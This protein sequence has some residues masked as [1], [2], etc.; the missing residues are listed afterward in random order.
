MSKG[1][2]VTFG[3]TQRHKTK[4]CHAYV[5]VRQDIKV[6]QSGKG[7]F[8]GAR[9]QVG[10]NTDPE[11]GQVFYIVYRQSRCYSDFIIVQCGK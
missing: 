2:I 10:S 8:G 11:D 4:P 7:E 6:N 5:Y 9:F 1:Q 3:R